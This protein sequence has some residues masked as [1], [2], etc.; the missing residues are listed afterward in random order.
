MDSYPA[1]VPRVMI[2]EGHKAI[3]FEHT[4]AFS[5]YGCQPRR[6]CSRISILY[7]LWR[8]S[9]HWAIWIKHMLEPHIEEICQFR[10]MNVVEKR[11][12]G[13]NQIYRGIGNVRA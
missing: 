9:G 10:I 8:A 12:I 13:N 7:L 5:E 4:M 6:K 11:W 3:V 2:G 1:F